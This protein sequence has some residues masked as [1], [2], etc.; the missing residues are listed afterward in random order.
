MG[1]FDDAIRLPSAKFPELGDTVAGKVIKIDESAIPVFDEKTGRIVPD[2]SKTDEQGN[3]LQ[4]VDVTLLQ[5]DGKKV[6]LHTDGGIFY[7][8]G[9]AL[10]NADLEDLEVGDTLSVTFESVAEPTAKGRNGAKQYAA[11]ITR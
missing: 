4:Q 11:T 2:K 6:T 5:D 3:I 8:I 9:L 1:R 10:A 7:A